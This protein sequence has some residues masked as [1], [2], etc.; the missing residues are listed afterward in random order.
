M[1][2]RRTGRTLVWL[3]VIVLALGAGAVFAA[4][5]YA[6]SLLGD[7]PEI[8]R[9][10]SWRAQLFGE[11]ITGGIPDL[12]WSE[13]LQMTRQQGGFGLE[14][15]AT[16]GLSLD[17]SV[18][19]P[20]VTQEDLSSGARIFREHCAQCHGGE[21]TGGHGPALNRSGLKHGDGDLAIYKVLRDGV[22]DTSMVSVPLDFKERWQVVSYVRAL[23]LKNPN[24]PSNAAA[25]LDIR[26]GP[27]S[28]LAAGSKTDEW[29]TFSGSLNGQRYSGLTELTP[30]NVSQLQLLWV[31]Q[32]DT[33]EPKVEATPLVINGVIFSTEPPSTVVALDAKSGNVIWRYQRSVSGDLPLC[34]GKVNRGLAVLG[35]LLFWGSL[36]G[37]LIALDAN[38][39]KVVWE[40]EVAKASNG[41]TLTG[42]P[43]VV[44]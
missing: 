3:A 27:E 8:W 6:R 5:Y 25:S 37:Y 41:Y 16:R 13:L 42:A 32:F 31:H 10:L 22:P 18:V 19:S 4:N 24:E 15:V 39:G 17:G 28:V 44:N 11:K 40:T 34:C 21:G 35:H 29:L 26:V 30:L 2:L 43:L 20:Y 33:N 7:D 38:T 36:D 12:F 9:K 14:G 23:Q 1:R